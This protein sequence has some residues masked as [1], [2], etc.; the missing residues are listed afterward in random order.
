MG[1]PDVNK[2]TAIIFRYEIRFGKEIFSFIARV[3]LAALELYQENVNQ[4]M[5]KKQALFFMKAESG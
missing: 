3:L 2:Q 1:V 4:K 5:E